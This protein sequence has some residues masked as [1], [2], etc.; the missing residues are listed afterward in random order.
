VSDHTIARLEEL[1]HGLPDA[2]RE[3]VTAAIADIKRV[4]AIIGISATWTSR[5]EI[6]R[7]FSEDHGPSRWIP[8]HERLPTRS[9]LVRFVRYGTIYRGSFE[10]HEGR[11]TAACFTAP[12]GGRY[13]V[14]SENVTHWMPDHDPALPTR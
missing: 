4:D 9:E 8:V 7:R 12:N 1:W 2:D 5:E 11:E 10:W 6:D 3:A 14:K 13:W